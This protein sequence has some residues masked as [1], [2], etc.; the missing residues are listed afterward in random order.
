MGCP[1]DL[2]S[3]LLFAAH[4]SVAN[5][6][7]SWTERARDLIWKSSS[8]LPLALMSAMVGVMSFEVDDIQ[9]LPNSSLPSQAFSCKSHCWASIA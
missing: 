6:A 8:P 1:T 9:V 7:R 2:D 5:T 3:P 4:K